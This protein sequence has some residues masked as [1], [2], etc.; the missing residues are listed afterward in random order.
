MTV[1]HHHRRSPHATRWLVAPLCGCLLAACSL[2]A[3]P[4]GRRPGRTP[5]AGPLEP[6]EV[7]GS[8]SSAASKTPIVASTLPVQRSGGAGTRAAE[9]GTRPATAQAGRGGGEQAEDTPPDA[10]PLAHPAGGSGGQQAED[11]PPDALPTQ[12]SA[13]G[14]SGMSAA[15]DLAAGSGGAPVAGGAA[16][17]PTAGGGGGRSQDAAGRDAPGRQGGV[18]KLIEDLITVIDTG[19]L[20][21]DWTNETV[22]AADGLSADAITS[23]LGALFFSGACF[24]DAT[25]CV[26]ACIAVEQGCQP[27]VADESCRQALQLVC[28]ESALRCA[29]P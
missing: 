27:C 6:H 18:A 2:D 10:P 3:T 21:P 15:P 9:G 20:P 23:L 5:D 13:A 25:P 26:A 16:Q 29:N 4:V 14:A 17:L 22:P 19:T 11:T 1:A 7:G 8:R 12:P 24:G 28:G